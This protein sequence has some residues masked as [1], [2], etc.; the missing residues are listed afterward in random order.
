MWVSDLIF[1]GDDLDPCPCI[2][3]VSRDYEGSC[4]ACWKWCLLLPSVPV[5]IWTSMA[6]FWLSQGKAYSSWNQMNSCLQDFTGASYFWG[7]YGFL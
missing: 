2:Q 7:T 4:S 3:G 1:E 6:F 5:D